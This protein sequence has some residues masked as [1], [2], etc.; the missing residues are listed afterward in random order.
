M[1][2][3]A[4]FFSVFTFFLAGTLHARMGKIF[5]A[6][7]RWLKGDIQLQ[8]NMNGEDTVTIVLK[9]GSVTL[10][11]SDVKTIVYAPKP[12]L[13]KAEKNFH[14]AFR[15]TS[16]KPAPQKN[17]TLYEPYIRQ[18]SAKY[19]LDP[20]LVKAVIKQESNF[21]RQ[22][23]SRKGAQGLMQLMPDTARK[24]GVEDAFDPWENIHGGVRYLRMMLEHF[25]GDLEKALAAYN[26]GP[27]AV[28][29]YG[30]I[31]PY[32]ETQGYVRNIMNYYQQLRGVQT[33]AF[34]DKQGTLVFSGK[35]YLP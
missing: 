31:P 30:T 7:G 24:L 33:Y 26:A 16:S 34:E 10:L 13:T 20:E 12:V 32:P 25:D 14:N 22:D 23:V 18:A 35:P 21:N 28:R 2:S 27:G 29:K 5:F 19:Q 11:R 1:T 3:R 8:K 9:S 15:N 4:I 6:N 17:P